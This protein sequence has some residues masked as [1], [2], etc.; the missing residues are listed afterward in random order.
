M[1]L[2]PGL[3]VSDFL[4]ISPTSTDLSVWLES[5]GGIKQAMNP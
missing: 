5:P 3:N 1:T 2:V 4:N